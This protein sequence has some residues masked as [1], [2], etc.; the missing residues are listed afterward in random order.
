MDVVVWGALLLLLVT[1][2]SAV[3]KDHVAD[4]GHIL[5]DQG[6]NFSTPNVTNEACDIENKCKCTG[7]KAD[8]S[9]NYGSLTFVPK[10]PNY[11]RFLNFSY[12]NLTAID[13]ADFF[14]NVTYIEC[15][16][17]G[18]NGLRYIH[19]DAF[20]VLKRLWKLF[21]DYND[22]LDY[23]ALQP[24]LSVKTLE[25]LDIRHGTLG[26]LPPDL[27]YR[28]PLPQLQTMYWHENRLGFLNFTDMKPLASLRNI[29][30]ATNRISG[31]YSDFMPR[32]EYLVIANNK[33]D[34]FPITCAPNGTSY[35]PRLTN[36]FLRD[37][38]LHVFTPS[39]CLPKLKMLQLSG[40]RFTILYTDMFNSQRFPSLVEIY[41][42][43]MNQHFQE[44][45]RNVFNNTSLERISL[46]YNG[47][48]FR[49][50]SIHAD[51][52]IGCP[53]IRNLALDD[54]DFSDVD[55][56]RFLQLFGHLTKLVGLF[57][58]NSFVEQVTLNTFTKF[59]NLQRLHLYGNE[60]HTLPDGVFDKNSLE[61]LI[62][63]DNR[64]SIISPLTFGDGTIRRLK[65][66]DLSGNLFS[67]S[68]ELRWFRDWM[69]A[70]PSLFAKS[71][72]K[73]MCADRQNVS[74]MSFYLPE[75]VC[76]MNTD[77]FKFIV[78]SV[79][80]LTFTMMM[81]SSLYRYRW[82]IRLVLYETFRDRSG[83]RRRR[84][85]DHVYN[86]DVFV[87]YA[88][89]DLRWV[90][91]RLMPE[92]EQRLGLRLCVHQRD[93]IPGK[94]IVDNIV[95]SVNDSKKILMV[96]STNFARSHW[97]QFE[98]AF[99]LRHVLEKGDD[100]IIVYLE[101]ILSRDLTS[102][103][104]AVL[105]TNTYIQWQDH[106]DAAASFWGRLEIALQEI[107]PQVVEL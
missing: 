59:T 85:Q 15:L 93:F 82:H 94:N 49:D 77:S 67:C 52:F 28:F 88:E 78:A 14:L 107:L 69:V 95:D 83:E 99:C 27:F 101:E 84:L 65:S 53:R 20:R 61:E 4:L 40:N 7:D 43:S 62:L 1:K 98:L 97:C 32:L 74:I 96:F 16:D 55:D 105:K 46:M 25:R 38:L 42:K 12:N 70:Q 90:Q 11:I 37:N 33:I 106:P 76:L 58:G 30:L 73:Y 8:C 9:Q 102:V 48:K 86:Y 2:A 45:Q 50:E 87:S 21:L 54:N 68:C 57:M 75:Q 5:Q 66:L 81:L 56:K 23:P 103:M 44:I 17:L 60:L 34:I 51:S 31:I 18:D 29:G 89:E 6:T 19:S 80:L 63:R 72:D 13:R 10:L 91:M 41:L 100:L 35:F 22:H 71:R 3:K 79:G 39:I 24:V 104:M 36:L 64:L 47:I 26:P 92:V